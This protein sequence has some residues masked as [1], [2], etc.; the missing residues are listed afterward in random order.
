MAVALG[1]VFPASASSLAV[2]ADTFDAVRYGRR[3]ARP[4]S[5]RDVIALDA[6][7]AA[8]PAGAARPGH[9]GRPAMSATAETRHPARGRAGAGTGTACGAP[10]P[11]SGVVALGLLLVVLLALSAQR[12]TADLDP[13]GTGPEGARALAEVLR[14]QGVEVE[15]VR[16]IDALEAA[17][18]GCR[19]H[20]VRR[21]PHQPRPG[22]GRPARRRGPA[23]PAGWCC[24][25]VD[26]EQ[27]SRSGCPV[28]AFG[29]G[30]GDLVA[31]CDS[32]VARASD[33]VSAWD[34]R[35][36]LDRRRRGGH[37]RAS[38]C[39]RPDGPARRARPRRRATA[40]PWCEL[41]ATA[42]HPDTVVAGLG[43]AW[44]NELITDDSHAGTA[45]RALGVDAPAGLVPARHR[46]PP[47]PRARRGRRRG[48]PVGL[49][50]VDRA[51]PSC[52]SLAAVV[53]LALARGR[54]LGRLVREPLPVVVRA[55]ETTESRGRLYR[56]AGDR[57]ARRRR[58]ARRHRRAPRPPARRG[59]RCRRR[60]PWCTRRR[61]PP[62]SRPARSLTSCSGRA[63]PDDAALIHLAQQLTDLEER[64][65]HP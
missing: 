52:C 54:R 46:R 57:A 61:W 23:R 53:L 33:V 40:R 17:A 19:H 20:G 10:R 6:D 36:L 43:P 1:P 4:E 34:S 41:D 49:A 45:V 29:G 60:L 9:R 13:E 63:P 7:L 16:S 15:V 35:Y 21:R 12:P 62:G 59:P 3:A 28:E 50:A 18:A 22:R 14:Q 25:G 30:G 5:A 55:I 65:R 64:V 48:R 26:S 42:A 37:A 56:R 44:S 11:S 38:C 47:G 2:A 24:V 31:G 32:E 27:L 39:P 8:H 51:R 58:A